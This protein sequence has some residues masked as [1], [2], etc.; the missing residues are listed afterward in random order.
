MSRLTTDFA[1]AQWRHTITRN[2]AGSSL[3][4]R[5]RQ[6]IHEKLNFVTAARRTPTYK[7]KNTEYAPFARERLNFTKITAVRKQTTNKNITDSSVFNASR[8]KHVTVACL[9]DWRKQ[10]IRMRGSTNRLRCFI[11]R[12]IHRC[13]RHALEWCKSDASVKS[14]DE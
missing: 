1:R 2:S 9:R 7:P 5:E 3:T 10:L 8:R 12:L 4:S 6:I 14:T 11:H 13:I